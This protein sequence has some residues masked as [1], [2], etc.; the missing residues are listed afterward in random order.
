LSLILFS[1]LFSMGGPME[2]MTF[3][4]LIMGCLFMVVAIVAAVTVFPKFIALVFSMVPEDKAGTKITR[5]DEVLWVLMFA[6]LIAYAT[7]TH[8]CGTHLW[9]CFIAGMSFATNH[10]AHRVWVRQVKRVT[11]WFLRIFF[12]STL[13]WSIPVESLFDAT[14]LWKGTLM[15]IGPCVLTKVLCAPFMGRPKWVI[16]WAMVGRA[17]FAYFIAIMAKSLKM[18]SDELFA[19]LIWALI[20]ATIF[21][22]LVFRYV[23]TKYMA[24]VDAEREAE[25]EPEPIAADSSLRNVPELPNLDLQMEDIDA[26]HD[27]TLGQA[28]LPGDNDIKTYKMALKTGEVE[29]FESQPS[30]PS[31]KTLG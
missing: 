5:H 9:G 16:G 6:T 20:Y 18:M 3:F 25:R 28:G 11:C 14:A 27:P 30:Q 1:V 29:P 7:I 15:G 26:R 17:E 23:L 2:F 22:P 10:D 21:A 4:P 24:T 13:A 19:V 31:K 8:F 12:A